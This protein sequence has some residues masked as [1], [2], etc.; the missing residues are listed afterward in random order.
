MAGF[1]AI[2]FEYFASFR[3]ASAISTRLYLAAI[4]VS[5][6]TVESVVLLQDRTSQQPSSREICVRLLDRLD[7]SLLVI[8]DASS[9]CSIT[10]Q[11][12]STVQTMTR[13]SLSLD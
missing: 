4:H 8:G 12:K 7:L 11:V 13:T 5:S 6:T 9:I 2:Q 10:I 3:H 1:M